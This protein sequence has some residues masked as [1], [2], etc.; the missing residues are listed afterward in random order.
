LSI[1]GKFVEKIQNSLKYNKNNWCFTYVYLFQN[2]AKFF[3]EREIFQTQ[4][5]EKIKTQF[6]IQ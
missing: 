3:F 2:V 6:Y 1:F 5:L 4:V